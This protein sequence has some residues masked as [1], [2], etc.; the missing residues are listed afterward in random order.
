MSETTL[1]SGVLSRVWSGQDL[2]GNQVSHTQLIT[3]EDS[4]API[5][6]RYPVDQTVAC[7]CHDFPLEDVHAL[8]NCDTSVT[9]TITPTTLAGSG[10]D[11]YKLVRT[12]SATDNENNTVSHAQTIT[13]EDN[14]AP[15]FFPAP[16]ANQ[17]VNCDEITNDLLQGITANQ[18]IGIDNCDDNPVVTVTTTRQN[19]TDCGDKYVLYRTFHVADHNGQNQSTVTTIEITDLEKPRV[20]AIERACVYQNNAN[21]SFAFTELFA[22]IDDCSSNPELTFS[23]CNSTDA[24][25]TCDESVNADGVDISAGEENAVVQVYVSVS[26]DCGNSQDAVA[27][28]NSF[29]KATAAGGGY[30]CKLGATPQK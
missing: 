11:D 13:V 23:H 22:S 7:S 12:Y 26:D 19:S 14:E 28:I 16:V 27:T 20:N 18:T 29:D 2:A 1:A 4:S 17:V 30:S 6:S 15:A 24:A 21:V 25:V 10:P 3:I 5:L 8:D 9:V